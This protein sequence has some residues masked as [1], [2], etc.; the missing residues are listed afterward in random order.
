MNHIPPLSHAPAW[1]A[2]LGERH[3]L[4]EGARILFEPTFHASAC[5]AVERID[6]LA[7]VRLRTV[8]PPAADLYFWSGGR[9]LNP[10]PAGLPVLPH[11][12]FEA[13]LPDDCEF[14][15]AARS[16]DLDVP[17]VDANCRDGMPT[18][19]TVWHG[20]ALLTLRHENPPQA[21]H[22]ALCRRALVLAATHLPDP[23]A[24]ACLATVRSY[25]D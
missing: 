19:T 13:A 20:G 8:A 2:L 14:F 4:H 11:A 25:L 17:D 16:L 3:P 15:A 7:V 10:D 21:A 5:L 1:L 22:L 9:R 24:R 12:A 23:A 18:T 6:G